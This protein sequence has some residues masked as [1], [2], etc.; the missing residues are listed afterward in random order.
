MNV[1]IVWPTDMQDPDLSRMRPPNCNRYCLFASAKSKP[2]LLPRWACR[3]VVPTWPSFSISTW[4]SNSTGPAA[5]THV[6]ST[7]CQNSA[8]GLMAAQSI[9]L[10]VQA[11]LAVPAKQLQHTVAYFNETHGSLQGHDTPLQDGWCSTCCQCGQILDCSTP[12]LPAVIECSTSSTGAPAAPTS[13]L[14]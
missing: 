5:T 2:F 12:E 1:T 13:L 10:H 6:H 14:T 7:A 9:P 4:S 3:S 8:C 11:Q